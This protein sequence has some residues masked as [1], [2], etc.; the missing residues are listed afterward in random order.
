MKVVLTDVELNG[1][2]KGVRSAPRWES[3]N[4]E[5]QP[6][7][8]AEKAEGHGD[9]SFVRENAELALELL[10]SGNELSAVGQ[11]LEAIAQWEQ[12]AK[13]KP[14]SNVPWNNMA[15]AYQALNRLDDARRV[16]E[17]VSISGAHACVCTA[18]CCS[19]FPLC[20]RRS[21]SLP[22]SSFSSCFLLSIHLPL[23]LPSLPAWLPGSPSLRPSPSCP[24]PFFPPSLSSFLLPSY[25]DSL[26]LSFCL[27]VSLSP[28]S[29]SFSVQAEGCKH[30][31]L[32]LPPF[33]H[34]FDSSDTC[35]R[36]MSLTSDTHA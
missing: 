21:H 19:S 29:L 8:N 32:S 20:A 5:D 9:G 22:S 2:Q 17:E 7:R 13:Y 31:S 4:H 35:R 34:P 23:S 15:N 3:H 16:A 25:P 27:L 36:M 6:E 33:L 12:A 30:I 26:S 28:L 10:I 24:T 14:D 11:H 18:S 1:R